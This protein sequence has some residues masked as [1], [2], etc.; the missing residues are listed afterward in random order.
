MLKEKYCCA[1]CFNCQILRDDITKRERIKGEKDLARGDSFNLW[2]RA[3]ATAVLLETY[4]GFLYCY[5]Q[6]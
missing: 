3:T 6:G 4:I 1:S 5:D 2:A